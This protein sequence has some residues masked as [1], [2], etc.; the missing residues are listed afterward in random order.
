MISKAME[1]TGIE[2]TLIYVLL[3]LLALIGTVIMFLAMKGYI[4]N[5]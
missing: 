3:G 5:L 2:L 4:D 1:P